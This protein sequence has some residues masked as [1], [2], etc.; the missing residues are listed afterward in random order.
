MVLKHSGR[1]AFEDRLKSLGYQL[2]KE[3]LDEVFQSFKELAD[4]KKLFQIAILKHWL[5]AE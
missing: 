2:S 4:R 5:Q 1:H 3:K